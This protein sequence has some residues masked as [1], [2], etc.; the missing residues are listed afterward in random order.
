MKIKLIGVCL[1]G[2]LFLNCNTDNE[3]NCI[4]DFTGTLTATETVLE[5]TWAL[6]AIESSVAIDLTDDQEDNAIKDIYSQSTDC[7]NDA[8]YSFLS[9]RSFSLK[10]GYIAEDCAQKSSVTGSWQLSGDLLSLVS[11]CTVF[12]VEIEVNEDETAFTVSNVVNLRDI[13]NKIVETN[14]TY[15]YTKN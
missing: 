7:Q 13:D 1:L 15:T 3:P 6:T 14:V 9:S 10:Q 8:V 11:S 5:G 4:A 2:V 12:N